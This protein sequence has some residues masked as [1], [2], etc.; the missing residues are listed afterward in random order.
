[1]SLIVNKKRSGNAPRPA[2]IYFGAKIIGI[3]LVEPYDTGSKIA[4]FCECGDA[5][6]V[7]GRQVQADQDQ[8]YALVF[9]MVGGGLEIRDFFDT[10]HAK[11]SPE[12]NNQGMVALFDI[13]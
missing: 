2:G 10:G 1:M 3:P 7:I 4:L 5:I 8:L 9:I 11:G 13:G 12:I 6:G